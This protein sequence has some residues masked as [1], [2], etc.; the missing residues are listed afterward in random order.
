MARAP[1]AR[2]MGLE[3]QRSLVALAAEN[4]KANGFE[5]R[6]SPMIGDVRAAPPR[7]GPGAFDHVLA[8][9]PYLEEG[10][11]SASPKPGRRISDME[12]EAKLETH[13]GEVLAWTG[14]GEE[15]RAVTAMHSPNSCAAD[16][17]GC[18]T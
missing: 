9:P 6:F 7:I 12:G 16:N 10:R 3:I 15:P 11:A 5:A 1:E 4:A 8:N 17:R 13:A 14:S 18:V 2:V